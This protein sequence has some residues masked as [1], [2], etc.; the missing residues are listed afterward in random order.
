MSSR[1]PNTDYKIIVVGSKNVSC[2]L[3]LNAFLISCLRVS[4]ESN[5]FFSNDLSANGNGIPQNDE[6]ISRVIFVVG[7]W[8]SKHNLLCTYFETN[9]RGLWGRLVL[10]V[11]GDLWIC[12]ADWRTLWNIVQNPSLPNPP[13]R[14]TAFTH[15]S[16]WSPSE[17]SESLARTAWLRHLRSL[18][19]SNLD[20]P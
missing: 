14:T 17:S 10:G 5:D 3:T 2:I 20:C 12:I 19:D 9:L 8:N 16:T 4:H 13:S 15:A 7:T 1:W 11:F 18:G 6:S